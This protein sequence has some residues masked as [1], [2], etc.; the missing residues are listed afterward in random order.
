MAA[1][2]FQAM[3][4]MDAC[5]LTA[6]CP[7]TQVL[8]CTRHFPYGFQFT[9]EALQDDANVEVTSHSACSCRLTSACSGNA[10]EGTGLDAS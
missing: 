2:L 10:E 9:K 3:F 8:F 7:A 5:T 1:C 6:G 4:C